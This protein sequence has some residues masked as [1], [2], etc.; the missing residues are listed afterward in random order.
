MGDAGII[1]G[2]RPAPWPVFEDWELP[3]YE[4]VS[5]GLPWV[6][7]AVP[8]DREL[9]GGEVLDFGGGAHVIAIPGHTEG[10][11]AIYLPEHRVLFTGDTIANVGQLTLGVFNQDRVQTVAAFRR[12]AE[13]DVELACLGHGEPI[14]SGAGEQLRAVVATL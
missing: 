1:R 6:A 9:A 11:I 2:E 7:P 3:I 10:S 4:R 13:L 12:L 14:L 5:V 8:V